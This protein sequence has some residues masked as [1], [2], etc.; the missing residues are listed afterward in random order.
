VLFGFALCASL[1]SAY[2][3]HVSASARY[4]DLRL[5]DVLAITAPGTEAFPRHHDGLWLKDPDHVA[6]LTLSPRQDGFE[7]ANT[8]L[9][10]RLV[11]YEEFCL[12]LIVAVSVA[13]NVFWKK[14]NGKACFGTFESSREELNVLCTC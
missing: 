3:P 2:P 9:K 7:E 14:M 10:N 4:T 11:R 5:H 6:R 1:L 8:R 12:P 13:M